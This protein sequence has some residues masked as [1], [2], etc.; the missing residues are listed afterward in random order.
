[1]KSA[2][3]QDLGDNGSACPERARYACRIGVQDRRAEWA[4]RIGGQNGLE[5]CLAAGRLR[6][7]VTGAAA[8]RGGV[9]GGGALCV[10]W[11]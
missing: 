9:A 1:M 3:L 8:A 7:G 2:E 4:C 11:S 5:T 10:G 6:V